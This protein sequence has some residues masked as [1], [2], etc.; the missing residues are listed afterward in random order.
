MSTVAAS[1]SPIAT[2]AVE[3]RARF[4]TRTYGH[5]LLAALG[6]TALEI[7]Y[8]AS[9][10]APVIAQNLLGA[11]WMLV[12]G[13]FMVVG[14]LASHFSSPAHSR[15]AQYTSLCAYV[16]AESVIFAPLLLVADRMAPGA[17]QSAA[18]VTVAGFIGLSVIAFSSRRDFTFLG[19]ILRWAGLMALVAIGASLVFG[20]S[21]G[22][23]FS[24]AMVALA[25]GSILYNTSTIL[26]AYPEDGYVAAALQLFASVALLFW[27]VLQLFMRMSS[28]RE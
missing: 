4:I 1:L 22:T 26:R 18:T 14:M 27:Y 13:G 21:L 2:Q 3:S 12:L 20:F 16:T 25:G 7:F 6:F 5:L 15:T 23:W 17:I 28:D 8:F 10:L 11:G 19:S 9:G 24:V